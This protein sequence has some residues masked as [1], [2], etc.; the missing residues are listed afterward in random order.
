MN[1]HY[2]LPYCT[3][4]FNFFF[5]LRIVLVDVLLSIIVIRYY[6][7][8]EQIFTDCACVCV[9]VRGGDTSHG[10]VMIA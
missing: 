2:S 8:V 6:I 3:L 5:P 4:I 1:I 7:L 9:C 10:A